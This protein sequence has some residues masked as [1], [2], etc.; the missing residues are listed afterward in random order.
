MVSTCAF[1]IDSAQKLE[2]KVSLLEFS[3]I[4][5][6]KRFQFDK[7]RAK[8]SEANFYNW[9]MENQKIYSIFLTHL[10]KPVRLEFSENFAFNYQLT[11]RVKIQVFLDSSKYLLVCACL[12]KMF[13]FCFR[14]SDLQY[15]L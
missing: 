3:Q 14:F 8:M 4:N 10:I 2:N 12:K 7:F 15:Q 5:N 6:K 11:L 13:V 1:F 9:N